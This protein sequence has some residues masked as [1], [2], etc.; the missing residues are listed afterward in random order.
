MMLRRHQLPPGAGPSERGFLEIA[1]RDGALPP[2]EA[3]VQFRELVSAHMAWANSR[4]TL[5]RARASAVRVTTLVLAAASAVV[6]GIPAIPSQAAIALPMVA[7][8]T[9][10]NALEPF[11]NWRSRWVLMEEAQYRLHRIRDHIDYYLVTT[12]A[13]SIDP[14]RLRQFFA[15]EQDVWSYV[16]RRGTELRKLDLAGPGAA[17]GPYLPAGR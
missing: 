12:P 15:D 6:L 9:L 5:F 16:S 13:D 7:L 17:G 3:L 10:L 8:V 1:G 2:R 11:Y 14:E 4:K